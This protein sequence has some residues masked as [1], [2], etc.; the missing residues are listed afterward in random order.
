MPCLEHCHH[1]CSRFFYWLLCTEASLWRS[2]SAWGMKLVSGS[3]YTLK[4]AANQLAL[5][6]LCTS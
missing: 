6:S 3:C 4:F 2:I 5:L 1:L